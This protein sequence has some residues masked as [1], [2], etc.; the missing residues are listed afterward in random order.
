MILTRDMEGRLKQSQLGVLE[1][2]MRF[3]GQPPSSQ[4]YKNIY[5]FYFVIRAFAFSF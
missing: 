2:R 4:N 1:I 5:L 3:W